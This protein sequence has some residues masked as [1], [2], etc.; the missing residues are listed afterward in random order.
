MLVLTDKLLVSTQFETWYIW[1][2][3]RSLI[4]S[5]RRHNFC[6]YL[7]CIMILECCQAGL[8]LQTLSIKLFGKFGLFLI[9][10]VCILSENCTAE[11]NSV[12]VLLI[13]M[14]GISIFSCFHVLVCVLS[15]LWFWW[16]ISIIGSTDSSGPY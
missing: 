16:S 1:F 10:E 12:D 4:S 6:L 9:L 5:V 7:F 14:F 13:S 3:L 15:V 11:T 2:M 8:Y